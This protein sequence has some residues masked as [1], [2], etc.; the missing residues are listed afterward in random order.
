[1]DRLTVRF[2]DANVY[3]LMKKKCAEKNISINKYINNLIEDDIKTNKILKMENDFNNFTKNLEDILGKQ[4]H[5]LN[6]LNTWHQINGQLLK[7]IL[8]EEI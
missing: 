1:M 3:F 2:E 4:I 5:L 6:N 8:E 7:E